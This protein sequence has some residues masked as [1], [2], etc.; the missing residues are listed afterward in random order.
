MFVFFGPV[1]QLGRAP[2]SHSGG[3][4]FEPHLCPQIQELAA[5]NR[6]ARRQGVR[7]PSDS[8]PEIGL[9]IK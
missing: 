4:G 3:R 7:P 5:R 9:V 8:W 1:A 6:L 2:D